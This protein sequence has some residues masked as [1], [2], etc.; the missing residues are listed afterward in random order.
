MVLWRNP[1]KRGLK[2]PVTLSH[3]N[4]IYQRNMI[5]YLEWSHW[6]GIVSGCSHVLLADYPSSRR[7][8]LSTSS[9]KL[10]KEADFVPPLIGGKTDGA[11]ALPMAEMTYFGMSDSR[12]GG[13]CTMLGLAVGVAPA[14]KWGDC[15]EVAT[16]PMPLIEGVSIEAVAAGI[17][18][19]RVSDTGKRAFARR[20]FY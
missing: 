18:S 8:L 17:F 15:V 7:I 9:H 2:G 6:T 10:H 1:S 12:Q 11:V 16:G 3:Q 5:K 14:S 20:K 4:K 19:A 13:V